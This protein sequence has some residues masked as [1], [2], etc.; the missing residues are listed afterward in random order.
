M[1]L[2][3]VTFRAIFPGAYHVMFITARVRST[4]GRLCF[5]TCLSVCSQ[6]GGQP[7]GGGSAG[8]GSGGGG[9]QP[10]GG[11]PG[12]GQHLA[13]S[14]GRYASC[15]HAGGLSCCMRSSQVTM[16]FTTQSP[17]LQ[18]VLWACCRAIMT[19]FSL[20]SAP[21][22]MCFWQIVYEAITG[23]LSCCAEWQCY[24]YQIQTKTIEFF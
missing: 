2:W 15:V 23:K 7:G 10:G 17:A 21:H 6:G 8:G 20:M 11:Q 3:T 24:L 1:F 5:D 12:G 19:Q 14:C 4:T 22:E 9:G 16:I 13:P 18:G